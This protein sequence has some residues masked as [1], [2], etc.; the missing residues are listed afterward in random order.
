MLH[1]RTTLTLGLYA[2]AEAALPRPAHAIT[3]RTGPSRRGGAGD[4]GRIRETTAAFGRLD[5]LY[6][7]GHARGAV[8]AYLAGDVAPLL[9]GTTGRARPALFTAAAQLAYLAGW[10]SADMMRPGLAQRYYIMAVRLADEAGDDLMRSTALRS[11]AVQA[12]ELGHHRVGRDLADAAADGI[13][14]RSP[15]R[16]RAWITGM[17]A[18]AAAATHDQRRAH[19]LLRTAETELEHAD[20]RPDNAVT[21]NYRRESFAHQV[22][23]TLTH[24]GDLSGAEEHFAASLHSRR[25]VERRTRALIGARLALTQLNRQH[26]DV[27][28]RTVLNLRDDLSGVESKRVHQTLSKICTTWRNATTDDPIGEADR[29]LATLAGTGGP[30]R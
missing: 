13:R 16:T 15:A 10:M 25:P 5:D 23:L 3:S 27:A 18:E 28:A 7:G 17:C 12:V 4:V 9:R 22:G 26:P 20:S 14:T 21:A 11:L 2:L 19:T 1:R 24:L 8:A 6:G 30:G 29:L